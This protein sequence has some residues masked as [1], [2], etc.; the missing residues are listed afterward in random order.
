MPEGLPGPDLTDLRCF[1]KVAE[2]GSFSG[3]ALALGLPKATLSRR[4]A[5]LERRL[6]T[7]LLVRTTRSVRCTAAGAD[8]ARRA[9]PALAALLEAESGLIPEPVGLRG[10]LRIHAPR[11]Y[12]ETVLAP[13]LAAFQHQH[14]ALE[15]ELL[16]G[17][18]GGGAA[19][20]LRVAVDGPAGAD[21][22]EIDRIHAGLY[23]SPDFIR[24][25]GR[26]DYAHE[27]DGVAGLSADGAS[28][29]SLT[30]GAGTLHLSV[31][32]VL[33]TDSARVVCAA[34]AAGLGV[35]LLPTFLAADAVAQ[36]RVQRLFAA[37]HSPERA[38]HAVWTGREGPSPKVRALL[39]HLGAPAQSVT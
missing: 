12:G 36:G 22:A 26:L 18:E 30:D 34:A 21:R 24:G 19:P 1:L 5:A 9:G 37:W 20:D 6:G 38:V 33:R 39:D 28:A 35:A 23:A 32:P 17:E 15:L 4:V 8:Y 29:W 3:A 27:L 7:Q 11:D 25:L 13:R 31:R 2:V 16:T 14:P 10:S